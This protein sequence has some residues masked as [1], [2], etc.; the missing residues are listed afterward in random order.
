MRDRKVDMS[1][2]INRLANSDL[3]PTALPNVE[4]SLEE[5][6]STYKSILSV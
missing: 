1:E 3:N 6:I 2:F 4:S 5:I